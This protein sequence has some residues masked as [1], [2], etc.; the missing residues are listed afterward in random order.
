MMP[1]LADSTSGRWSTVFNHMSCRQTICA[2][3]YLNNSLAPCFGVNFLETAIISLQLSRVQSLY[4]T[5][6]KINDIPLKITFIKLK[7][8]YNRLIYHQ[9]YPRTTQHSA[10]KQSRLYKSKN[11]F[12]LNNKC[13]CACTFSERQSVRQHLCSAREKKV[14]PSAT[15][16][17]IRQLFTIVDKAVCR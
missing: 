5:L 13:G 6:Y 8:V 17:P 4:W 3:S 12:L 11:K 9:P 10:N 16:S 7:K 14:A 1:L 2:C 15:L